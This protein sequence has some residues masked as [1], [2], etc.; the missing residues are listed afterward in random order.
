MPSVALGRSTWTDEESSH[1][2]DCECCQEEWVVI[3]VASR[4]GSTIGAD[5]DW[6]AA[7]GGL[8]QRLARQKET[9]RRQKAWGFAALSGAAA[10]A[11]MLWAG[12]PNTGKAPS[13]PPAT[14]ASLKIQLPELDNLLPAELNAVLQTMDEPSP[15]SS[16]DRA[17]SDSEDEELENG[18]DIWEG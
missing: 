8:L 2:A 4:L 16:D 9:V 7:S 3:Q 15:G 12:Q 13:A 10:A 18:F 14:V 1:L 17:A 6:A 5:L 11:V